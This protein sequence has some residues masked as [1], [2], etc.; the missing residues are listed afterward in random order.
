METTQVTLKSVTALDEVT[1]T[2]TKIDN[3]YAQLRASLPTATGTAKSGDNMLEHNGTEDLKVI[4]TDNRESAIA[5]GRNLFLAA[6]VWDGG[7]ADNNWSNPQNW[8]GNTVPT[9]SDSVVFDGTCTKNVVLNISPHIKSLTITADYTGT[10]SGWNDLTVAENVFIQGGVLNISFSSGGDLTIEN[11]TINSYLY[12]GGNLAIQNGTV[13]WCGG[14]VAGDVSLSGGLVS[15]CSNYN[16][17]YLL[18]GDFRRTGGIVSGQPIF[19]FHAT[20]PQRF[21]PG[22]GGMTLRDLYN[23]Y[24]LTLDGDVTIE[25]IFSNNGNFTVANGATLDARLVNLFSNGGAIAEHG[26]ILRQEPAAIA[27]TAGNPVTSN[28]S[29]NPFYSNPINQDENF[30]GKLTDITQVTVKSLSTLDKGT[31]TLAETENS[32]AQFRSSL[33][34]TGAANAGDI[35]IQEK[36][37][38][39]KIPCTSASEPADIQYNFHQVAIV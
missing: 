17:Y 6:V 18:Y 22:L 13:T 16:S 38:E 24:Q 33:P 8:S 23:F 14:Q 2:M 10:L 28:N 15:F 29:G 39:L 12:V 7:G 9:S 5:G 19:Y 26:I 30:D 11:G 3:S 25:G 32:S 34:T 31:F 27:G 20:R 37:E 4:Y 35:V 1:L 21:E 36:T